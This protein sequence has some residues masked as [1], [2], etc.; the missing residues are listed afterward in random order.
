[1][2]NELKRVLDAV[3]K[4]KIF[5]D[6]LDYYIGSISLDNDD[7][8]G[9]LRK[10]FENTLDF[11]ESVSEKDIFNDVVLKT[12]ESTNLEHIESYIYRKYEELIF[13]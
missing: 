10:V 2:L 8:M 1:M 13:N 12:I 9:T 3:R 4:E 7:I 11:K 5:E 6:C